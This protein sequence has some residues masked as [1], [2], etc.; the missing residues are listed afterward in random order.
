MKHYVR[1]AEVDRILWTDFP[2]PITTMTGCG[3]SS[4]SRNV[5]TVSTESLAGTQVVLLIDHGIAVHKRTLKV[6]SIYPNTSTDL[7][8]DA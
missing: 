2:V 5:Q 3:D 1:Q 8:G 6:A 4:G 7:E